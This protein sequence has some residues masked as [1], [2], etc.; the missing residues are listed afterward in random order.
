MIKID[1]SDMKEWKK[2]KSSRFF[3]ADEIY[4]RNAELFLK[5]FPNIKSDIVHAF[6]QELHKIEHKVSKSPKKKT[7]KIEYFKRVT[8]RSINSSLKDSLKSI[9]SIKFEVEYREGVLFDSPQ[10]GGFDF[11]V[12]DEEKNIVNFR[13]YCFGRKPVHNG[14]IE[15]ENE[16]NKRAD[17]NEI[18]DRLNLPNTKMIGTDIAHLKASPTVIGEIQLG[19]WSLAYY[20]MF[21]VLHLDNLAD[22]DL[23]IYVTPTGNLNH[24][25]S[26]GIVN[27][28]LMQN[29]LN[30]YSSILKVPIWLIGIDVEE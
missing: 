16:L 11:A 20:D 2:R 6:S 30:K 3:I 15:W 5:S 22:L 23:L 29:I 24:Y 25:L 13:N 27:Y 7:G 26:D 19:N 17:W 28:S 21:K 10:T 12:F 18:A 4:H 14:H 9:H 1:P 8:A